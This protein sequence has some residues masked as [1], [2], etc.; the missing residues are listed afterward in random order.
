MVTSYLISYFSNLN[1]AGSYFFNSNL[2]VTGC[3][4]VIGYLL[5][6]ELQ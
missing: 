1:W 2:L 6:S 5:Q 4:K 3:E